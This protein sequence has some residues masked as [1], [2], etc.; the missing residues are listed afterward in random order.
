[1]IVKNE[2]AVKFFGI[3]HK[4]SKKGNDFSLV[5]LADMENV[6]KFQFFK[7][8]DLNVNGLVNGCDVIPTF[9]VSLNGF[10]NQLNLIDL[11]V[12]KL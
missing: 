6:E 9:E 5:T 10:N 11:K 7:R 4:S 1:M 8:D 2:K 3:E 12:V